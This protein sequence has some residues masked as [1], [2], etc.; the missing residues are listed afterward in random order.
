MGNG[1]SYKYAAAGITAEDAVAHLQMLL[2][3]YV[4]SRLRVHWQEYTDKH[5]VRRRAR[6]VVK[7]GGEVFWVCVKHDDANGLY[8]ADVIL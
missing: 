2:Q 5:G 7:E 8:T 4:D 3:C 6:A 1:A